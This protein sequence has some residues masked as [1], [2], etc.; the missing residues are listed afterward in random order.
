MDK[1]G[2][3]MLDELFSYLLYIIPWVAILI[4]LCFAADALAGFFIECD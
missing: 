4:G 3:I 2:V 1:W